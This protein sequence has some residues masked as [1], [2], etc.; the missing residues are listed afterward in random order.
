[1]FVKYGHL[2]APDTGTDV[3]ETVVVADGL[4]LVVRIC[5]A[6]LGGQPHYASAGGVV[7]D[8]QGTPARGGDHLVA[9]E[10]HDTET[11]ECAEY[12]AVETRAEPL[13]GVLDDRYAIAVGNLHY[14]VYAVGHAVERHHHDCLGLA[15]GDGNAV[16]YG[17]V[18]QVGVYVPGLTLRVDKHRCGATVGHG[19]GRR[20]ECER[21]HHHLVAAAHTTR[22]QGK[23]DGRRA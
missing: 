20:A 3:R 4:V 21:L 6:G 18:K 22:Q 12:P 23:M 10:R 13:R 11:S 19:I 8:C 5:L 9:V 7:G 16:A 17:G 14:A 1:M 2:A 15:A